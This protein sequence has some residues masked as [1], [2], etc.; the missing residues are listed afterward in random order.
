ME[1]NV[2]RYTGCALMDALRVVAAF[3]CGNK[4]GTAELSLRL[5]MQN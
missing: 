4:S 5:L 2:R 1:R 3:S